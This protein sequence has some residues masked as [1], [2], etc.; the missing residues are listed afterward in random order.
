MSL[1]CVAACRRDVTAP[2]QV[3]P[4]TLT[5]LPRSL[6]LPE[7]AVRDASNAFSFALWSKINA[8]Q[9]GANVFISPLSASFAL[10]MTMNG[11]ATAT[12][13]QMHSALQFG[14]SSLGDINAGYKSLI[15]LLESLDPSVKMQIANS[16]WYR[17]G[18]PVLP[19]FLD[20]TSTYFGATVK[21]LNFNDQPASLAAINGW[22]SDA[23]SAKIPQVLD[24][25]DPS[26]MMFLINAIYFKGSWRSRFDPALTTTATFTAS[27]STTQQMQLMHQVSPLLYAETAA[28]QAVDLSYGDSAFTM[29][30]LLPKAGT[31]VEALAAS[32]TPATWQTVV[33]GLHPVEEVDLSLPKLTLG[34]Q[35]QMN[36]DLEALGMVEPFN[37][38]GADFTRIAS[39]PTGLSLFIGFVQQNTFLD[40]NEEGTEA[41]AVTTVGVFATAAII[42]PV[43][44]VD[45]PYVIVI[46]E[47]LSGTVLVLGKVVRMP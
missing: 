39:P 21:G 44:R 8:A 40:I 15:A 13:D 7:A 34:Y 45:R 35:R 10:G 43:M 46:R 2:A 1:I 41:A 47:R 3:A 5:Q 33:A 12:Y 9:T 30:V 27:T 25:I 20:S 37:P 6:T 11:A 29:T 24:S 36:G 26:A 31:D 16:V 18:F 23:T 17:A 38:N 14:N 4:A 22:V 32:L 28:Y 42:P 19:S